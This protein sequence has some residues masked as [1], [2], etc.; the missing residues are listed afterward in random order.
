MTVVGKDAWLSYPMVDFAGERKFEVVGRKACLLDGRE[1]VEAD[2]LV[3]RHLKAASKV[4]ECDVGP[5]GMSGLE[6]S[7]QAVT[8]LISYTD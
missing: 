8:Q 1:E 2:G 6:C 5:H 7:A 3:K 4:S